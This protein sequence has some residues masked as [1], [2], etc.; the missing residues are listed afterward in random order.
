M[1]DFR[2]L[3][4]NEHVAQLFSSVMQSQLGKTEKVP[5]NGMP[6]RT[7]KNHNSKSIGKISTGMTLTK[8]PSSSFL[9]ASASRTGRNT[10]TVSNVI[11]P[12]Q[13]S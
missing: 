7:P 2:S 9:G 6:S 8:N 3:Q 1:A 11:D 5:Q 12:Q 4:K 13:N 10:L